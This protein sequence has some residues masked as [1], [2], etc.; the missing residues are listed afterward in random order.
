MFKIGLALIITTIIA[1]TI[2]K[3]MIIVIMIIITIKINNDA[4]KNNYGRLNNIIIIII[5]IT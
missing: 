5:K 4:I 1:I 3:I 2:T